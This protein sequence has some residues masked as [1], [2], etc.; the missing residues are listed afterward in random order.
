MSGLG[1]CDFS[2]F[3]HYTSDWAGLVD[4]K[5][6]AL[7]TPCVCLVEQDAD[8]VAVVMAESTVG[9]ETSACWSPPPPPDASAPS[10]DRRALLAAVVAGVL[11]SAPDTTPAAL[12][13]GD[14]TDDIGGVAMRLA[15]DLAG[16]EV[17]WQG[18]VP[19]FSTSEPAV[20]SSLA[21]SHAHT[22]LRSH[23]LTLTH[24][25][26][27]TLTHSHT[28]TYPPSCPFTHNSE[29][30]LAASRFGAPEPLNLPIAYPSWM[31]GEWNVQYSF[32]RALF[33]QTRAALSLRVPGAGLATCMVSIA[34]DALSEV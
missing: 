6:S 22:L 1:L 25:Y 12:V 17:R 8:G 21:R 32:K 4:K 24:S 7:G 29:G 27:H 10:V 5:A 30:T 20:Q 33:P 19:R 31:E 16:G 18:A 2:F 34:D 9:V 28:Q 26:T 14:A 11:T 13:G 3:P 15:A 23:A